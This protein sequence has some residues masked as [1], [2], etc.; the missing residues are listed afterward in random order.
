[1][2]VAIRVGVGITTRVRVQTIRRFPT[3]R[4]TIPVVVLFLGKA[5]KIEVVL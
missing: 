5:I 4:E 1:V 2:A 3:I